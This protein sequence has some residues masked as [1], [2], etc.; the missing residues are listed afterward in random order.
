MAVVMAIWVAG[1]VAHG[2]VNYYF[3]G[4]DIAGVVRSAVGEVRRE[5]TTKDDDE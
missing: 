2:D 4:Q 5:T 3:Y 1:L